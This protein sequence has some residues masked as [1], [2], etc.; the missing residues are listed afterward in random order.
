[1]TTMPVGG[2]RPMSMGT[3]VICM[4]ASPTWS[5]VSITLDQH[6]HTN[7]GTGEVLLIP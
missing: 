3:L 7:M 6:I 1:M 2:K 4:V 5:I